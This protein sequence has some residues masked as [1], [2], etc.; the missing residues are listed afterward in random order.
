M[1]K[2][3]KRRFGVNRIGQPAT[4]W[5]AVALLASSAVL[6]AQPSQTLQVLQRSG[7]E[8]VVDFYAV[9][10]GGRPVTDLRADAVVLKIDGKPRAI[11]ALEW[12]PLTSGDAGAPPPPF[13]AN[14]F[15]DEGR[16]I[17]LVVDDDSFPPGR[18][19]PMRETVARF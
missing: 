10:A 7:D 5:I 4:P 13:G 18:E 19:A 16:S 14:T 2:C 15:G 12:V 17:A 6:L 9:S 8:V 3:D 1:T 11:R